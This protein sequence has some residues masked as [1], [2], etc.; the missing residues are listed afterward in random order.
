MKMKGYRDEEKER[1]EMKGDGDIGEKRRTGGDGKGKFRVPSVCFPFKYIYFTP[2]EG[3]EWQEMGKGESVVS[4]MVNEHDE[5]KLQSY[6]L[7][8]RYIN[9]CGLFPASRSH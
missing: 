7:E 4:L 9:C 8:T 1:D 3:M 2:L 6:G 5:V